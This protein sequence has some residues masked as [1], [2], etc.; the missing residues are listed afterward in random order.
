MKI[1]GKWR[2]ALWT[3]CLPLLRRFAALGNTPKLGGDC[4]TGKVKA[5]DRSVEEPRGFHILNEFTQ[6][7]CGGFASSRNTDRLLHGPKVS[8]EQTRTRHFLCAH[9]TRAL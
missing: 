2:S 9:R 7:L 8:F 1:I 6:I 5:P 3:G 4:D